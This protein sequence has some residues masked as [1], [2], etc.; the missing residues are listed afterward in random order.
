MDRI[1]HLKYPPVRVELDNCH[2]YVLRH[3]STGFKNTLLCLAK[4]LGSTAIDLTPNTAMRARHSESTRQHSFLSSENGMNSGSS[5]WSFPEERETMLTLNAFNWPLSPIMKDK[6]SDIVISFR[7]AKC[8]ALL[9]Q[10]LCWLVSSIFGI[11]TA[12]QLPCF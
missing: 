7:F 12:A 8:C 6:F 3:W 5:T 10:P 4:T 1:I 9:H 11:F 2:L